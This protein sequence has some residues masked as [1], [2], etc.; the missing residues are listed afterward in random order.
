MLLDF[1]ATWCP[2]C[3]ESVPALLGLR[4]KYADRPFEI[5]GISSD[6]DQQ[7]WQAFIAA[8]HMDWPDHFDGAGSVAELFNVHAF[9]TYI[10]LDRDGFIRFRQS[11]FGE[12]TSGELAE[13]I[14]KALKRPPMLQPVAAAAAVGVQN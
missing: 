13:A 4:K 7:V 9:P 12:M 10:V 6:N 5:V 14:D 8:H 3:R 1:W 2:P 11:G